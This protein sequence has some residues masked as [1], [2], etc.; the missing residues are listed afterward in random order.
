LIN[1]FSFLTIYLKK[2]STLNWTQ[3]AIKMPFICYWH[4]F[5]AINIVLCNERA[6]WYFFNTERIFSTFS[7]LF[8]AFT[9]S[10]NF[11]VITNFWYCQVMA[12]EIIYQVSL[13]FNYFSRFGLDKN[14]N[15]TT[16]FILNLALADFLYCAINLPIYAHQVLQNSFFWLAYSSSFH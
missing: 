16:I 6:F 15:T 9:L 12:L 1:D 4:T 5:W 7:T 8:C 3:K 14:W 13:Y 11:N 10:H 2:D